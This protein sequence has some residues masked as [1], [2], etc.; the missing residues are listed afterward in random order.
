MTVPSTLA[1]SKK[2]FRGIDRAVS[3]IRCPVEEEGLLGLS[4]TKYEVQTLL[5]CGKM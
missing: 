4:L 5:L 1:L 2:L 3:G